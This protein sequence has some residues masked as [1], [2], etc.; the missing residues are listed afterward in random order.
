MADI[1]KPRIIDFEDKN[2]LCIQASETIAVAIEDI[3]GDHNICRVALCGGNTP[4]PVYQKIALQSHIH[5]DRVEIYQTDERYTTDANFL[6]QTH[7]RSSLE[8]VVEHCKDIFFIDTKL[9][10]EQAVSR[11]NEIIDELEDPIFDLVILGIGFDGHI[12]SL[13]PQGD[14]SHTEARVVAT[15]APSYADSKERISLSL[16]TILNSREIIVLLTGSEKSNVLVDV[17]ENEM[18]PSDFPAKFLLA[19]PNLTIFQSI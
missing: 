18:T 8:P 7:I 6:N 1:F 12:A 10:I 16:E 14:F 2:Q 19:H 15:Q 9:P 17:L 4:T 11:Y 3:I 13:F 5:W